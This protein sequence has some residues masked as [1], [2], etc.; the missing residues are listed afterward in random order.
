MHQHHHVDQFV[1]GFANKRPH[2]EQKNP[3]NSQ[4]NNLPNSVS[5][6]TYQNANHPPGHNQLVIAEKPASQLAF[7]SRAGN[8]VY[9]LNPIQDLLYLNSPLLSLTFDKPTLNALTRLQDFRIGHSA[10]AALV[11][12]FHINS[13]YMKIIKW[14]A[15]LRVFK[16]YPKTRQYGKSKCVHRQ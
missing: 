16:S 11:K 5:V 4:Q 8:L 7:F 15:L 9:A 1:K 6:P 14:K 13:R 3:K 12:S 2:E 10:E